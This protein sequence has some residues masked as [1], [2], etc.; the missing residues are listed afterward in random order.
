MTKKIFEKVR[1]SSLDCLCHVYILLPMNLRTFNLLDEIKQ[2]EALLEYGVL[3]AE[4]L[5]K[6]FTIYLYQVKNFYVEVYYHND[7]KM[8]QGFRGFA[9]V[10]ALDPYLDEIDITCL[11]A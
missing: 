11:Q 1:L 10:H 7:F 8:I 5:Y 6:R 4:R 9:G 3:V 2:A